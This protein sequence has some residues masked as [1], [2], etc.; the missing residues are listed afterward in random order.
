MTFVPIYL[1]ICQWIGR[2][3]FPA[4]PSNIAPDQVKITADHYK[5]IYNSAKIIYDHA[6]FI[7]DRVKSLTTMI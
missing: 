3:A 5:I 7:H 6:K 1:S 2:S 4:C